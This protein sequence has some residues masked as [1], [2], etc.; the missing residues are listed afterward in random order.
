MWGLMCVEGFLSVGF[1]HMCMTGKQ[2]R[3]RPE[4]RQVICSGQED[5]E[6]YG[7]DSGC[8]TKVRGRGNRK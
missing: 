4:T 5:R 8:M 2:G 6:W 3:D 1:E 7:P